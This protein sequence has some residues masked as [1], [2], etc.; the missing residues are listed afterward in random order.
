MA[1]RADLCGG[2]APVVLTSPTV[3]ELMSL[4][5]YCRSDRDGDCDWEGCPQLRDGEPAKSGRHCPLDYCPDR[6]DCYWPDCDCVSRT[7]EVEP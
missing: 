5:N 4:P 7:R 3:G 1:A 6:Y 2:D